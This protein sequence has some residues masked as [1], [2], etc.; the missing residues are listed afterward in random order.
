MRSR[1]VTTV[2]IGMVLSLAP[3]AASAAVGQDRSG[4]AQPWI[5]YQ[6]S[7]HEATGFGPEGVWL[8]HADGTGDH[9]VGVGANSEQLLP[10]WSPDGGKLVFTTRG[11]EHEPLFEYMLSSGRARQLF[12]CDGNCLGD[13]EPAYSPDGRTVAFVRALGP[14]TEFGPSDCSLW[15]GDVATGRVRRLT[16]NHSCNREV[17][18]RWSPDGT[19]LTYYRERFDPATEQA[20][21]AVFVLR[22]ATGQETRLTEW[23]DDYGEPDWSPDGRWIVMASHPLHSFN[24]G[25]YSSNLFRIRP[26][27]S[28]LQPL[29]SYA[30]DERATQPR[31]VPDGRSIVFTAVT[32]TAR[33]LWILPASGGAPQRVTTGGIATHGTMQPAGSGSHG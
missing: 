6:T 16:D 15:L 5:A 7:Y 12:G 11:G 32:P 9:Q 24:F 26:N 13:E 22:I 33:E 4:S 17:M 20:A 27:G 19:R 3:A 28:G 8:I 30:G 31:Y 25:S 18:P 10:D 1:R 14:F 21:T 23:G 2:A 29:T